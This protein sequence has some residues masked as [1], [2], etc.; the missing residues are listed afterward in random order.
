MDKVAT[1]VKITKLLVGGICL[2]LS[3]FTV[4]Y[5]SFRPGGF[6]LEKWIYISLRIFFGPLPGSINSVATKD[7]GSFVFW[8]PIVCVFVGFLVAYFQTAKNIYLILGFILW[9]T[10]GFLSVVA[11]S[12]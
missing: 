6:E 5:L 12:I 7:L 8:T 4:S 11:A 2:L 3:S 1:S 9:L 10:A